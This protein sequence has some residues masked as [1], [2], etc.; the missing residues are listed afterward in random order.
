MTHLSSDP[1]RSSALPTSPSS[2]SCSST[3]WTT[4][5]ASTTTT[6]PPPPSPPTL[7]FHR[8]LVV[9]WFGASS[10]TDTS[11]AGVE[12]SS[13]RA[14]CRITHAVHH[15]HTPPTRSAIFLSSFPSFAILK[16]TIQKNQIAILKTQNTK[17]RDLKKKKSNWYSNLF[18]F[19][20][21]QIPNHLN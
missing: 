7:Q 8:V 14:S 6:T 15:L 9:R 3:W 4:T 5:T 19:V 13:L 2:S 21:F 16:E 11:S 12:R 18:C 1:I 20:C 17:L 10:I